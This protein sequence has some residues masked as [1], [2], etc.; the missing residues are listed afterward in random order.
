MHSQD[1]WQLVVTSR[2]VVQIV[3]ALAITRLVEP[4]RFATAKARFVEAILFAAV[5]NRGEKRE[6]QILW[7]AKPN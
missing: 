7:I 1:Y 3:F 4:I 5:T 6:N 2:R